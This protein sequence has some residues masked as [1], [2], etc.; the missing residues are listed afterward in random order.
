MLDAADVGA[1]GPPGVQFL[2]S[3]ASG[4]DQLSPVS[5]R[6]HVDTPSALRH[7][8]ITT[9]VVTPPSPATSNKQ[10]QHMRSPEPNTRA[11]VDDMQRRRPQDAKAHRRQRHEQVRK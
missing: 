9:S 3:Q 5:Q 11:R 6:L 8:R 10:Q 4:E 7:Q 2:Q 1:V